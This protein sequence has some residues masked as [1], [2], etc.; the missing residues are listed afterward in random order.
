MKRLSL[1]VTIA[2]FAA[3]VVFASTGIANASHAWGNYHWARTANPFALQVESDVGSTWTAHLNT[4]ISDWTASTVLDLNK[5]DQANTK[6]NCSGISGKV[7]VCD[8]SYGFNGWLGVAQIWISGDHIVAGTV[9]LNDSYFGTS[10][11]NSPAWRSLVVCQEIGH[12]LG[13]DHQDE[14][15]SNPNL[16]TCMDYTSDPDGPLSNENPN[17]H[18]YDELVSIYSHLDAFNSYAEPSGG[19]G[20]GGG[21]NGRGN[22]RGNGAAAPPGADIDGVPAGA[23]PQ[24]GDVFVRDLGNGNK[25]ITYVFWVRPGNPR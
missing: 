9:K 12:T 5:V 23:G 16:G 11:Y 25:V 14:N 8:R 15:F 21:G 3:G 18:D 13:L 6:P 4:A 10:T 1:F 20:S 22:G 17:Q 7:R 2:L 19:G 24:D